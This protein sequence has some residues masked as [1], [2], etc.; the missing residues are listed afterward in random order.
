MSYTD[1]L[2]V[3]LADALWRLRDAQDALQA[4]KAA[5]PPR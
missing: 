1:A 3:L 2:A 5:Q 4:Q